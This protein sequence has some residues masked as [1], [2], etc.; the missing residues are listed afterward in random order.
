M[1]PPSRVL[2]APEAPPTPR[3]SRRALG[4]LTP[5]RVAEPLG[6]FATQFASI[7][8]SIA[9]L[10]AAPVYPLAPWVWTITLGF[11][12]GALLL[13]PRRHAQRIVI[14]GPVLA[15]VAWIAMTV[16][17]TFDE[18]FGIFSIRRDLPLVVA[19]SLMAS[20]LPKELALKAVRRGL[21]IGIALTIVALAVAPETRSHPSD[22]I[23]LLPYPGWHGYFIHKNVLAP[24]LVFAMATTLVFER[25][26]M[27]RGLSLAAIIALLVGSDSA[28]GFS[29]GMFVVALWAWFRFFHRSDGRQSTAFVVSSVAVGLIAAMGALASLS[30]ITSAYGK[31]LTFSG[32][33]YI[34]SAVFSAIQDRPWTGYGIGGVFFNTKS[35]ITRRIWT[36]VGFSIPHSHNGTLDV[37]LNYGAIGLGLTAVLFVTS[38]AKGLRLIRRSPQLG[39]WILLILAAQLLM[40]LSENV[41]LG[42]WLVYAGIM[43]GILQR[44]INELARDEAELARDEAEL[45][46]DET[47]LNESDVQP[48]P[49][50]TPV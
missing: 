41:F 21:F 17:W 11:P 50:P 30:A 47:G 36:D 43:R 26:P 37:W 6:P 5:G 13:A 40:G 46:R 39:E 34:W 14:D 38:A 22:G 20:L 25:E 42:S 10:L 29:A 35:A 18:P 49:R 8:I 9:F 44:E 28:T 31:D 15:I 24:Y 48:R 12:I 2:A 33:T 16:L 45:A 27:R 7:Y 3:G 19:A 23:Y 32:R 4:A 1:K